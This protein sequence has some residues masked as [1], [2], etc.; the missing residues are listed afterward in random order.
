MS[1]L[2]WHRPTRS[3]CFGRSHCSHCRRGWRRSGSERAAA[4]LRLLASAHHLSAFSCFRCSG[5]SLM[6]FRLPGPTS[7]CRVRIAPGSDHQCSAHSCFPPSF[8]FSVPSLIPTAARVPL[9]FPPFPPPFALLF[10]AHRQHVTP[11]TVATVHARPLPP[12]RLPRDLS[13]F[14]SPSS[15]PSIF[16]SPR[17][18]FHLI[19]QIQLKQ[20]N[21][22]RDFAS[23]FPMHSS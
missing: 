8:L 9:P 10:P 5:C 3:F 1:A 14:A 7:L 11:V 16:R 4:P 2:G 13:R 23:K 21:T 15:P 12:P 20:I 18:R 19:L 17:R 22:H 6:S